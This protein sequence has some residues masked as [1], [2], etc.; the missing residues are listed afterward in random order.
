MN[1]VANPPTIGAPT[2]FIKSAPVPVDHTMGRRP[3]NAAN[4][5]NG[6]ART[7]LTSPRTIASIRSSV[8]S[9]LP[10]L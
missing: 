1:D 6:F 7:H 10:T 8:L 9:V 3:I 4:T 5:V 2:R